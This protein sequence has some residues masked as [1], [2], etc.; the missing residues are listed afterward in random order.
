MPEAKPAPVLLVAITKRNGPATRII[1]MLETL[2]IRSATFPDDEAE[3]PSP[4]G[5]ALA[6]AAKQAAAIIVV[7]DQALQKCAAIEP[8]DLTNALRPFADKLTLLVVDQAAS[9]G[10]SIKSAD[11]I[12]ARGALLDQDEATQT[13]I[14]R[15]LVHETSVDIDKNFEPAQ[16]NHFEEYS[17]LFESTERLVEHRRQSGQT[18]IGVNAAL[19]AVVG[20]LVKDLGF[21]G[22]R[23]ALV[24]APLFLIGMLVCR[25]WQRTILQYETLIDWRYRQ[26]RRIERTRFVGSYR[27]F[28]REWEAVY[29]PRTRRSFG[30]SNLEASV[31]RLFF[32]MHI[33]GLIGALALGSGL[34]AK[35]HL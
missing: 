6:H 22:L 23:L 21:S 10:L 3:S 5:R 16:A 26:L 18:F 27:L 30:F 2:G 31:P 19:T 13:E 1:S 8:D 20:F 15:R 7:A 11:I 35:L 24:T 9:N 4:S 28:G 12:P 29:A 34:F 17:L 33:V 32:W 25:L 14:L